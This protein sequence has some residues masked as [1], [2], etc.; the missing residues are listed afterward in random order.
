MQRH[1]KATNS[2]LK[3][4]NDLHRVGVTCMWLASKWVGKSPLQGAVVSMK[5]A[6]GKVSVVELRQSEIEILKSIR[7]QVAGSPGVWDFT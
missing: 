3:L 4:E 1:F 2:E 7:Y 5:V 6:H